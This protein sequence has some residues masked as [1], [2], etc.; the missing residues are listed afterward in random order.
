VKQGL[1]GASLF[2]LNLNKSADEAETDPMLSRIN[3]GTGVDVS[4]LEV[5]QTLAKVTG[6]TVFV[7]YT[8]KPDRTPRKLMNVSLLERMG[9]SAKITLQYCLVD[10]YE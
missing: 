2:V 7:Y 6:F 4:I 1:A 5:V 10:T 3:V 9:W 8:C